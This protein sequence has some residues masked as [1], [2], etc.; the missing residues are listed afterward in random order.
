MLSQIR[1]KT[2]HQQDKQVGIKYI[3]SLS[4]KTKTESIVDRIVNVS[5]RIFVS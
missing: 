5:Y 1:K 4:Y 2:A 3:Y